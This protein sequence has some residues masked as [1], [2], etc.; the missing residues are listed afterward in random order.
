MTTYRYQKL[1]EPDA[2][3]LI[4]LQPSE[5]LG[6]PLDCS[7]L[8]T[9]LSECHNNVIDKY[10]ALSYVWGDPTLSQVVRVDDQAMY[11]TQSLNSALLHLR[12]AHRHRLIWADA[13]CINQDDIDERNQQVKQMGLVYQQAN[14]TVIYLGEGTSETSMFLKMLQSK[15]TVGYFASLSGNV[16]V[17]VKSLDTGLEDAAREWILSRPWFRRVWILQELVLSQDPWIQCGTSSARWSSFH[18]HICE[19]E[20]KRSLGPAEKIAQNMGNLHLQYRLNDENEEP[21]YARRLYELLKSRKGC[22][23]TDARDMLFA[24]LG[25]VS[26]SIEDKDQFLS[27]ITVNYAKTKEQVYVDL[28]VYLLEKL[29]DFRMFSLLDPSET[30]SDSPMPSWVPDWASGPPSEFSRIS[31]VLAYDHFTNF[32]RHFEWGPQGVL[33]CKGEWLGRVEQL[34]PIMDQPLCPQIARGFSDLLQTGLFSENDLYQFLKSAFTETY[35]KWRHMLTTF[36]PDPARV[37]R[38]FEEWIV[39]Q[40]DS[41]F[42][43]F[44]TPLADDKWP[45]DSKMDHEEYLLA[46]DIREIMFYLCYYLNSREADLRVLCES[47]WTWNGAVFSSS[48]EISI[49]SMMAHI[50]F[51]SFVTNGPNLFFSRRLARLNN[52]FI[53]LV[54]GATSIGDTISMPVRS[55]VVVPIVLRTCTTKNDTGLDRDIRRYLKGKSLTGD[56]IAIKHHTVVGECLVQEWM[57]FHKPASYGYSSDRYHILAIH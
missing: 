47:P 40:E 5:D 10:T 6:T 4:V 52:N 34:T 53:A 49:Q 29:P 16:D 25:L 18:S 2:I 28:A 54:P 15:A 3:R 8:R 23:V 37:L 48:Y 39:N 32:N 35:Q 26:Y 20:A 46:K 42:S 14:H 38:A 19:V 31:D 57:H 45:Y 43:A 30:S 12:D 51:S 44:Q 50:V 21:T 41:L 55:G 56:D 22:G 24:N 11:I 1:T 27:L 7:L 17:S 13:I 33:V 9:S 36:I